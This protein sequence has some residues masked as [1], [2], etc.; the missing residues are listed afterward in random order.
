MAITREMMRVALAASV[1]GATLFA[2]GIG[3]AGD[4]PYTCG[5]NTS[6]GQVCVR[7]INAPL[8]VCITTFDHRPSC[9]AGA[10]VGGEAHSPTGDGMRMLGW[11]TAEGGPLRA[12][13]PK[14]FWTPTYNVVSWPTPPK[15]VSVYQGSG[16]RQ[17]KVLIG[18][19]QATGA[20]K[21]W[22]TY[23]ARFS[24]FAGASTYP[25]CFGLQNASINLRT[26]TGNA[27]HIHTVQ[28]THCAT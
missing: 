10:V 27:E 28:Q 23:R 8:V 11:A 21:S 16:P 6:Q 4:T 17:V 19:P 25:G 26:W 9:G 24:S 20:V 3:R 18:A 5:P 1:I 12:V 22:L 7:A 13:G 14:S 2:P 15:L